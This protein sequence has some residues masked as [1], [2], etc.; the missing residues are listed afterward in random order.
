MQ[1]PVSLP[2]EDFYWWGEV[3]FPTPF[4]KYSEQLQLSCPPS[5]FAVVSL[6]Q[7]GCWICFVGP[8]IHRS[9][10]T[11]MPFQVCIWIRIVI[12]AAIT[13][14]YLAIYKFK[15]RVSYCKYWIEIDKTTE[16]E[17]KIMIYSIK[18][19]NGFQIS[20]RKYPYN[21]TN[22]TISR[23]FFFLNLKNR[24]ILD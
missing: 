9:T 19:M 20:R 15:V 13:I 21:G 14:S 12:S 18:I 16:V 11:C 17:L 23:N 5:I 8:P 3:S 6:S 2:L 1:F 22:L 24:L 7:R 10:I 4:L